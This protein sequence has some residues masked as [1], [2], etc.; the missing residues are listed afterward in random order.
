MKKNCLILKNGYVVD[1]ETLMIEKR[2]ISIVDGVIVPLE[3]VLV[4]GNIKIID[5]EGYYVSPGFIDLHVHVF[6]NYTQLGIDADL[7]GIQQGVTT[8]VDAGSTGMDDYASFKEIIRHSETEILSFLNISR[9]GL[10]KGLSELANIEDLMTIEE[11]K[12][13]I[14]EPA[15]VGLKARMSSSVVK[16]SG[17][18]PLEYARKVADQLNLPIMVHIGNPPPS[19]NEIF[20]L[21]NKGD[22]VTHA[23]HGKKYGIMNEQGEMISEAIEALERGVCFDIGHGTSSFCYETLRKFKAI[24]EYPFTISTDIYLKNYDHPVGSLM[25]T[26]SKLLELGFS[27]EQIV[28]KVTKEAA[29]VL[30]LTEQGTLQHG[31]RADITIFNIEETEANL[32]DS[33]G[34]SIVCKRLLKPYMTIRKGKVVFKNE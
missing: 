6:K 25:T 13:L 5:C 10:C 30:H 4:Y 7:V 19:L 12:E 9:K 24:Y 22:I 14:Y 2:N 21:L 1:P 3:V 32:I 29:D 11:A 17:I 33:E 31:T 8:I 23:F 16:N 15:I 18:K 28:R 34:E 26:M 27:L 20:P